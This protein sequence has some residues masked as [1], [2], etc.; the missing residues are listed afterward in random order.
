M[1][2]YLDNLSERALVDRFYDFVSIGYVV[3]YFI[4]IELTIVGSKLLLGLGLVFL[5][6]VYSILPNPVT[7]L[8]ELIGANVKDNQQDLDKIVY[9]C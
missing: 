1:I 9:K 6:N 8:P 3:S 4:M 7:K 2:E 5:G